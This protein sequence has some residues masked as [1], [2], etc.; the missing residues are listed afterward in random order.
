V[1]VS[2]MALVGTA[3]FAYVTSDHNLGEQLSDWAGKCVKTVKE[4]L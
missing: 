4:A 2:I 1:G 3:A